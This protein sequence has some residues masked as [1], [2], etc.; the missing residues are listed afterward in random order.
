[1]NTI[2]PNNP[3]TIEAKFFKKKPLQVREL[4]SSIR[5]WLPSVHNLNGRV[6][7]ASAD[8]IEID[9]KAELPPT[10]L[11]KKNQKYYDHITGEKVIL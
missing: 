3:S 6:L 5:N 11:S 1:M 8:D 7:F 4:K 2:K 10:E 9:I